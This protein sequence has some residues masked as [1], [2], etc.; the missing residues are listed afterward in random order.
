MMNFHLKIAFIF[1]LKKLFFPENDFDF[2][3][4]GNKTTVFFSWLNTRV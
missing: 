3:Q 1:N 2:K 4:N